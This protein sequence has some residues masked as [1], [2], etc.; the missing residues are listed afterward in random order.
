MSSSSFANLEKVSEKLYREA[1]EKADLAIAQRKQEAEKEAEALLH[2][3]QVEAEA[4]LSE[5][6]RAL[7]LEKEKLHRELQLA[8]LQWQSD[9]RQKTEQLL[10]ARLVNQPL[11]TALAA[12]EFLQKLLLELVQAFAQKEYRLEIS[13]HW[14]EAWE[15]QLRQ[16][17]P[18]LELQWSALPEK[19]FR[20]AQKDG[21]HYFAFGEAEFQGLLLD[22][23]SPATKAI[24][25]G[26]D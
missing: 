12:P 18:E 2:K 26:D 21:R 11:E 6:R 22:Y 15:K 4:L 8:G 1:V 3:A 10:H 9:L 20:L 24:L 25:F 7:A 16:A 13:E 19:S 14:R 17:L 5:A 23:L